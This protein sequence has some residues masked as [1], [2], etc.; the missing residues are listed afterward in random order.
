MCAWIPVSVA[1]AA[2]RS[3][4]EGSARQ[5]GDTTHRRPVPSRRRVFL[6]TLYGCAEVRGQLLKIK[7]NI[8]SFTNNLEQLMD[9]N[10]RIHF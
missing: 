2:E 10:V 6:N 4:G 7:Q 8:I 3:S 9:L 1:G 5:R